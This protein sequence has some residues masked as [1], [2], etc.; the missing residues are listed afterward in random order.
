[1]CALSPDLNFYLNPEEVIFLYNHGNEL[2]SPLAARGSIRKIHYLTGICMNWRHKVLHWWLGWPWIPRLK[3]SSCLRLLGFLKANACT[4]LP[5]MSHL[6]SIWKLSHLN[7][8]LFCL[9]SQSSSRYYTLKPFR[10][11]NHPGDL[12]SH[13]IKS[14][15]LPIVLFGL[16]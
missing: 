2:R 9:V 1:M 12:R 6:I 4:M 3:W 13:Q 7:S 8:S 14:P 11:A 10:A 16:C 15:G 5:S